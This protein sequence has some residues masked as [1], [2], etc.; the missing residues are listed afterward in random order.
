MQV[1]EIDST[2]RAWHLP[3]LAPT[4]PGTFRCLISVRKKQKWET[5]RR[6]D[7]RENEVSSAISAPLRF[8]LRLHGNLNAEAQRTQSLGT[9]DGGYR[10]KSDPNFCLRSKIA[11]DLVF[12]IKAS[13]LELETQG[14][15]SLENCSTIKKARLCFCK[16]A[17]CC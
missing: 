17:C 1:F 10:R 11:S 7:R 6:G 8:K 12:R 16:R 13:V 14:G 3:H 5:Q 2:I 4:A 15:N 9:M